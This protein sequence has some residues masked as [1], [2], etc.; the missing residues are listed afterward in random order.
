MMSALT[1]NGSEGKKVTCKRK[2][3]EEANVANVITVLAG[4]RASGSIILA[5]LT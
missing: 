2:A 5:T 4:H 3:T 1:F